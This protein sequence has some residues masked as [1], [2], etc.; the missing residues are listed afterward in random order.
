M[1]S[2]RSILPDQMYRDLPSRNQMIRHLVAIP[3]VLGGLQL[4]KHSG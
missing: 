4:I 2:V 1:N 3:V